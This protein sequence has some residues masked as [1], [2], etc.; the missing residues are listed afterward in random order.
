LSNYNQGNTQRRYLVGS[1]GGLSATK[2]IAD[3]SG[4]VVSNY[5][6]SGG[7][8][9][10][11]RL[12]ADGNAI[13]YL[14]DVMGSVIGLANQA[15]QKSASFA[16]DAFGNLRSSSGADSAVV[17]G[18]DFRFQGQWLESESGL[19][20]FRARDY[21]S[22]TGLFLSRDA[23]APTDQQPES[24]N[25]YQFAYQNPLV[26]SDP[27]GMFTLAELNVSKV[28]SDILNVAKNYSVQEIKNYAFDKLGE[29]VTGIIKRGLETMLPGGFNEN[30]L[31]KGFED[32]KNGSS[33]VRPSTL[34]EQL[35]TLATCAV[36]GNIP[37]DY[38]RF[39][40]RYNSRNLTIPVDDGQDCDDVNKNGIK[41]PG[42]SRVS[43]D[44]MFKPTLPTKRLRDGWLVGDFK[45]SVKDLHTSYVLRP[46]SHDQGKQWGAIV[47]HA[48]R[49]QYV[50][51]TLFI[52]YNPGTSNQ[53]ADLERLAVRAG[54]AMI[55]L[56]LRK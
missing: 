55:I 45:L 50:P 16:Y 56:S 51:A 28:I 12:D 31:L 7:Y 49:Y 11:L 3:G 27:S 22:K 23:V 33:G 9:P 24:M 14:T 46:P 19:Y 8:T 32:F 48:R 52:T 4:N 35:A 39:G 6:Y 25:P 40:V 18:G 21:D 43:I 26:Y 15:G 42:R 30:K 41:S 38:L 17:T 1:E 44:F 36:F 10:F 20:Y 34:F 2:L 53:K 29:G 37:N 5:I 13:Y 54:V 47:Q